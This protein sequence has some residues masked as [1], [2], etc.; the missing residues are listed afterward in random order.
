MQ[1]DIISILCGRSASSPQQLAY[2]FLHDGEHISDQWTYQQLAHQTETIAAY[3]QEA[4]AA[5]ERVLLLYPPGLEFIAAF[6][7][8]LAAGAVAVPAY[9]PR[10]QRHLP[11][12]QTIIADAGAKFL[13]TDANTEQRI[14]TWLEQ[15]SPT[16]P[17]SIQSTDRLPETYAG[18]WQPPTIHESDLAFLQ[19]TSGST[20]APKGVMV[21]HG[22][23]IANLTL[24]RNAFGQT[25]E[26]VGVF[27]LPPY[28]D[29]GLIGGILAP[30]FVG[31]P[32]YLL[33]P[34]TFL[35]RPQTWLNAISIYRATVSG[36]P[37]F[38][39]DL[40]VA[41]IPPEQRAALDLSSW[42]LAFSGAEPVRAHTLRDFAAAF[43]PAGFQETAFY[44]CYGLAEATLFATGGQHDAPPVIC[45]FDAKQLE[46]RRVAAVAHD[47]NAGQMLVG[48]GATPPVQRLRIVHPETLIRCEPGQIGEIWIAGASVAQGYWEKPEQT[49]ATFQAYVQD[50]GDGPFLRTG[51]LGFVHNGELFVTGRVKDLL[52]IRGR[53][54]HPQDIELTVEQSAPSVRKNACAVF[55]VEMNEQEQAV[56]VAEVE[57]RY[58]RQEQALM[59]DNRR[60]NEINEAEH[61]GFADE[62]HRSPDLDDAIRSIRQAVAEQHELQ[63]SAVV[64]IKAASIPRTSSGK[65]RRRACRE[66]FLKQE[67]DV[68]AEWR[69]ESQQNAPSAD[70]SNAAD[71]P[72]HSE[73]EVFLGELWAEALHLDQAV[74]TQE[75][76]FFQLG[77]DSL[78]ATTL[79]GRL[80]EALGARID[81][82]VLFQYPTISALS[83]Y[84][85]QEFGIPPS[86]EQDRA[87]FMPERADC[88]PEREDFPLLPLQQ[89]FYIARNIGE[90][91]IYV[92]LDLTLKG[93]LQPHLFEQALRLLFQRH[94]ALRLQFA[95]GSHGPEQRVL[96]E[97]TIEL[98]FSYA[99]LSHLSASEQQQAVADAKT[100]LAAHTFAISHGETFLARLLRMNDDTHR[101]LLNFDHLA[102]DGFSL[103][104]WF[105]DLHYVYASLL[106][107]EVVA[108]QPQTSLSFKEYVELRA[109]RLSATQRERDFA[110]WKA[111][112]PTF[113]P[114][115]AIGDFPEHAD[116]EGFETHIHLLD[117]GVIA[118]LRAQAKTH[119]VTF[120]SILLATYFKLI[121][122]WTNANRLTINT[123]ILNRQHYA[124]DVQAII[125]CF[126]DI[127]PIRI[128]GALHDDM[129]ALIG[130]VHRTLS[131]MHR[132][133]SVSGVEIA[134]A[135]AQK[136]HG[137]PEAVSPMIFSSA[138]FPLADMTS[139]ETYQFESVRIRTGAPATWL[140]VVVY[141]AC[142]EFVCSWNFSKRKFSAAQ[143]AMLAEQ[144]DALLREVAKNPQQVEP[145]S[146]LLRHAE[147]AIWHHHCVR[148][149]ARNAHLAFWTEQCRNFPAFRLPTDALPTAVQPCATAT[150]ALPNELW[151]KIAA[152]SQRQQRSPAWLLLT[153]L[154][155]LAARYTHQEDFALG[156]QIA[157]AD[158]PAPFVMLRLAA[159]ANLSAQQVLH[160]LQAVHQDA[161][162]HAE[163]S[164]TDTLNALYSSAQ[165]EER[166]TLP[167]VFRYQTQGG[168]FQT[169]EERE[170][171]RWAAAADVALTLREDSNRASGVWQYRAGMFEPATISRMTGHF[172]AILRDL[173]DHPDATMSEIK[174]LTDAERQQLLVEWN[175]TAVAYPLDVCLHRLIEA[176]VERTP[177]AI[178]VVFEDASLTY[179]ELNRRANQLAHHLQASG[180]MPDT[181]VGICAERSFEMIIGLLAVMKAGGAYVPLD[182]EYP[183]ECLA[184]MLQD[185]Q[186]PILLTQV[187]LLAALPEHQAEVFCLDRDWP[188]VAQLSEQ[189]PE[190]STT[191]TDLIYMIYTSGS[192]GKPKGAMNVHRGVV[193]RLLWMQDAYQ[194]RPED[195]ILQKTPFSFDVSGWE[196]W[197]P[198]LTGARLVFARPGGHRESAYL[199]ELIQQQQIT[200]LHF[201]PPMLQVFLA[202]PAARQ[203]R[204]LRRVMCSGEALPYDLQQRFFD[205]FPDV[206]LHNLYGP[207]EAAI[208][209][210]FWRCDPDTPRKSVPIG[211]PIANTQT[212]VLDA[213]MQPTPIGVPGELYLG[214]V[215]L[216]RGYLN[217]PDLTAEKF[218]PD[219]FSGQP[220]ARLY[221]TGDL[222]RYWPDGALEYLGRLDHQVK[223]RGFRIE[224]GEIE[225]ALASHPA[226]RE[227]VV[228]ARED[229]PGEKRLA[230]YLVAAH[231]PAP[232]IQE[233]RQFLQATLPEYMIPAAFV[234]LDAMPLNPNGKIE[235]R[236][237]PIPELAGAVERYVAPRTPTEQILADIWAEILGVERV[238]IHDNFFELGGHSLMATQAIS[239]IREQFGVELP[240]RV[241]FEV[242]DIAALAETLVAKQLEDVDAQTLESLLAET[243]GMTDDEIA[244]L[245]EESNK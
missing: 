52:I 228:V 194:L 184:F 63:A 7:G 94:P 48:C 171:E 145:L 134:R 6:L 155:I 15:T 46:N 26:S 66:A 129:L 73:W 123:P 70:S 143:I 166:P 31:F 223:I 36:G 221:K 51:D 79:T 47:D 240:L 35:Q 33:T 40:C 75:S 2:T 53:N 19:Y 132:H 127:L 216:A 225:T 231:T 81:E 77:G 90:I 64:L 175:D 172:L 195:R 99:D 100:A 226:I 39:Y 168:T 158:S 157:D 10:N 105:A 114:F 211:R 217:R 29:M 210:T 241:L 58:R 207:T 163:L 122:A 85:E 25:P 72:L 120:F 206:E 104:K 43:A 141:E 102:I 151:Q 108:S 245:L 190:S 146:V 181:L 139:A 124:H 196:F 180:V 142:D 203:C 209:V 224:L 144:Y 170:F 1:S 213:A 103:T 197:W 189:N 128:E 191:A 28:H 76:H 204:S 61:I 80:S 57:R 186:T 160:A 74:L 212:Y 136:Q 116:A 98:P 167:L 185:S 214:G 91:A 215:N 22:N 87:V 12:I 165:T 13:L 243:E 49:E 17:L 3:L 183:K 88:H 125:G 126:T 110:Y 21:T 244:R 188:T 65:I 234:F 112:I 117:M 11:R 242:E 199:T 161:T 14:V 153:A 113:E 202:E 205:V 32:V 198:L 37:N 162:A 92:V 24:I 45:A 97:N 68:L 83:L 159:S 131:D 178:A 237:L 238:G 67:L 152:E 138:L 95:T 174:M 20:A 121:A 109:A 130:N 232:T 182:P 96:P 118:Q 135:L 107:G 227:V 201:V 71:T 222:V 89:S 44:P 86:K 229:Q 5:G 54:L 62:L 50:S 154:R 187:R 93:K 137:A 84:L 140:D 8:C 147:F 164:L 218:V 230:A 23:L 82:D 219:P 233:L 56:I 150:F 78:S 239:R 101:L 192:T 149:A 111:Q 42:T 148:Q 156:T 176:Q 133:S 208:D 34:A 69:A 236:A 179:R 60:A 9:P 173:L 235:R 55:S 119:G 200:T 4:G 38:A 193:N 59:T 177:D 115:P 41:K 106:R 30:L 220:A 16:Q 169:D 27:W 18:R